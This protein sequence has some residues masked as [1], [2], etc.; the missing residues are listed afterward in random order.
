LKSYDAVRRRQSLGYHPPNQKASD[1]APAQAAQPPAASISE[2]RG[3]L[4]RPGG[5]D[6]RTNKT[7]KRMGLEI[8]LRPCG[9]SKK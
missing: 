9:G 2:S 6:A 7:A 1:H 3:K 4:H 5:N 8:T